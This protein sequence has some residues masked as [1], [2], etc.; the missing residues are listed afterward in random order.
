MFLQ[1][2]ID[3]LCREVLGLLLY[4]SFESLLGRSA[5]ILIQVLVKSEAQYW[6]VQWVVCVD[7]LVKLADKIVAGTID[8]LTGR[9][10]I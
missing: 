3:P 4:L 5:V 6:I 8:L 9:T 2:G 7:H 10:H 1:R